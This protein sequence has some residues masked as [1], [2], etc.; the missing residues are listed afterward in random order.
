[1]TQA[2]DWRVEFG[3]RRQFR[4][5]FDDQAHAVEFAVRHGGVVVP[6]AV[7]RADG[8]DPR[9]TGCLSHPAAVQSGATG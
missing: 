9:L 1:M 2:T 3:D 6:L 4:A 5:W 8:A 7:V